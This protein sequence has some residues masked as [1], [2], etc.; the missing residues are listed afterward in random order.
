MVFRVFLFVTRKPTITPAE[1]KT[2]WDT[3]H[4]ELLKSLTKE[5]FPITHTRHCIA[6]P[7]EENGKWPAAVL[8]G[9]QEDFS[10]DGI[11]EL[12]FEDE[13][14]FKTFYG[15]VSEPEVAAKIAADEDNFILKEK[16]R[17]VVRSGTAVTSRN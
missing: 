15:I 10:Y 5:H 13:A 7:T 4:V 16:T 9:T 11:A 17:A 3:V 12:A 1:F 14:A 2:H 6:R 8:V